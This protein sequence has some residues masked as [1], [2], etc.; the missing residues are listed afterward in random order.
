MLIIYSFFV[1]K[2]E[3]IL[4]LQVKCYANVSNSRF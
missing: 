2:Y 4:H 3:N 1:Q